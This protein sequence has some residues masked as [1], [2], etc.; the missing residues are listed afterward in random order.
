MTRERRREGRLVPD[1]NQRLRKCRGQQLVLKTA[2][3]NAFKSRSWPGQFNETVI[4]S[5][6][7]RE[8]YHPTGDSRNLRD[9]Q[10]IAEYGLYGYLEEGRLRE[11]QPQAP[12]ER[13]LPQK[14]DAHPYLLARFSRQFEIMCF[15]DKVKSPVQQTGCRT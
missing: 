10:A 13:P 4:K 14:L 7:A 5:E 9:V 3:V 1:L 12:Q 8:G 11:T 6:Q 15:I 2:K